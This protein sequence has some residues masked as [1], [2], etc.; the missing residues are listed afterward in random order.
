MMNLACTPGTFVE[1]TDN[2]K[3]KY[4]SHATVL[5]KYKFQH[6]G[7]IHHSSFLVFSTTATVEAIVP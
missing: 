6:G 3:G 1:K 2:E 4:C 5:L 7:S